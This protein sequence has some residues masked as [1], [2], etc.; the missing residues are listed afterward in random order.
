MANRES[1]SSWK[2]FLLGLRRRGFNGVGVR[3]R[4]R[5]RR[6]SHGH[7]R[8]PARSGLPAV[9]CALPPRNALDHLPRKADDDCLR[10]LRWLYGQAIRRGGPAAIPR[11]LDRQIERS[12]LPKACRMGFEETIEETLTFY[13]LPRQHHKHLKSTNVL[14]S[15]STRDQA[16]NL[17][18]TRF[19]GPRGVG[20]KV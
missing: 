4:R 18:W 14:G 10:E 15:A 17:N 6:P 13:R 11:R 1:R 9:L 7:P 16:A 5:S 20:F 12:P 3:R 8:G 2:D 19:V